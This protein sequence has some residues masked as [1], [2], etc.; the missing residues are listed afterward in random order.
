MIMRQHNPILIGL[1]WLAFVAQPLQAQEPVEIKAT[2]VAPAIYMLTG[3][4]GNLGLSV[5]EDGA[6]LIDDQFAPLSEKIL[7]AIA[8]LT[9]KP[10]KFV[11]NTHWHFDHTGGN[12]NFGK[13]GSLIVA[14]EKVR[15]RL[16]AGGVIEAFKKEVPPAPAVALPVITFTEAMTFHFNGEAIR[17]EHPRAAHTDGDAII[18]F[19]KANVVHMGDTFFNGFY[20]FVDAGSGGSLKGVIAAV[21]QVLQR[22][23]SDTRIIPGHGPLA[24]K[25]QLQDYHQMLTTVHA[26]ISKLKAGGKSLEQVVAAKPTADLDGQWGKGFLKPDQW[27]AIIYE[28]I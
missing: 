21:A 7:A 27:V 3:Q 8:G 4:G 20:P 13:Q 28:A 19:E 9:D 5:G 11:L 16:A 15:E 1:A 10:V 18:Y 22:I 17:V 24:T 2:E 26:R 14:H 23:D 25:A 12:E 6:F